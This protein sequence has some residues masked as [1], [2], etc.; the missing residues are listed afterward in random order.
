MVSAFQK[1][2]FI[3][4]RTASI[5]FFKKNIQQVL[6]LK[7]QK[8]Q[9]FSKILNKASISFCKKKKQKQQLLASSKIL[10]KSVLAFQK[11][12]AASISFSKMLDKASISF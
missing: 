5:S 9:V 3:T 11:E 12:E 10:Y 6:A 1:D 7:K 2:L 4:K 8:Q